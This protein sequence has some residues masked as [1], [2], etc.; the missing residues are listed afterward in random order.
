M[1]SYPPLPKTKLPK[2]EWYEKSADEI[3]FS[4]WVPNISGG[5]VVTTLPMQT[6][7]DHE[8]NVRYARLAEE[9]GF[10]TAL[11]QTRWF[12]SYGADHQHEAFVIASH[13]LSNTEKIHI[14]TACHPGLWHPGVVSKLQATLDVVSAGRT[15]INIVSGWFKGEFTGYGEPWLEHGERYRRSEEF[16]RI[17]KGMWSEEEFTLYGDFYTIDGAPMLPKPVHDIPVFQG[18]N[19]VDARRMAGRVSD[20]LFMNGNTN[21]GFTKIM[22][23]A[24]AEAVAVG[25]DPG[26]V[27][28][29]SNG[30]A[31]VRD[32]EEEAV[33]VLR[34]IIV[35]A[36]V[37]AV[38]GFGEAVKQ[39]GQ[40]S[41]QGEGMWAN[42]S[43]EDLVQYNDGFKTGLIG[44]A[45]QVADRIMELKDLG[46][47]IILCGFLHY[48][49]ELEN[50]GKTVIPLVREREA[51]RKKGRKQ[52][53]M[54]GS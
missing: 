31:I 43:F 22:D 18:G 45:D 42:S 47:N 9:N 37:E 38:K 53:A 3:Q 11:A 51:A 12:A 24:K 6:E 4:Y 50:F 39:A 23:G 48:D 33:E 29:G 35:N 28:F 14:I 2:A 10:T 32:T 44:T 36:D 26:E 15:C 34:D 20:V 16:I 49:W 19:S 8:S 41:S 46:V 1:P 30:F 27:R 21:E 54:T 25:R 52:V 13:I 40:S 17:M 7:W 5:L